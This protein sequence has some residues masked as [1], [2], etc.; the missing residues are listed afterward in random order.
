MTDDNI[1][2]KPVAG[3]PTAHPV[4]SAAELARLGGGQIAYIRE[5]SPEEAERLYPMVQG[6]PKGAPVFALQNA[7]GT[8]IALTDTRRAAL[9][10]AQGDSLAVVT[11]H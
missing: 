9:E 1:P 5:L 7:D 4:I 6:L 8:P 2:A 3:K 10:H 11:V